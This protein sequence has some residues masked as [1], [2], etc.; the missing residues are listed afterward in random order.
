MSI[1]SSQSLK[2]LSGDLF[3]LAAERI[4]EIIES[5]EFLN[6]IFTGGWASQLTR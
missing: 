5:R 4:I 3:S 2:R 6:V 1:N